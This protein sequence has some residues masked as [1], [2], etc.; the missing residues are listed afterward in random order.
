MAVAITVCLIDQGDNAVEADFFF[1]LIG[2]LCIFFHILAALEPALIVTH[3]AE[4]NI[5]VHVMRWKGFLNGP[6]V[7]PLGCRKYFMQLA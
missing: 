1:T 7:L 4:L 3:F 6:T 5:N 2:E